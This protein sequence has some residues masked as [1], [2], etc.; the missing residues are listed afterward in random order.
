MATSPKNAG[1]SNSLISGQLFYGTGPTAH[2][3]GSNGAMGDSS[4]GTAVGSLRHQMHLRL[5]R[6]IEG[7]ELAPRAYVYSTQRTATGIA[8]K[9]YNQSDHTFE[10]TWLRGPHRQACA[11]PTCPRADSFS[12]LEWSAYALQGCRI[13]CMM[14]SKLKVRL[15]AW[16]EGGRSL[17]LTLLI[18]LCATCRFRGTAARFAMQGASSRPGGSIRLHMQSY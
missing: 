2:N 6:P 18:V 8:N 7:C 10:F 12:P 11:N 15:G 5:D 13:Q 17:C 14:C 4:L 9:A 1:G 16:G 3:A